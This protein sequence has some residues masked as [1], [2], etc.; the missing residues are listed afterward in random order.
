MEN[1]YLHIK[2]G[3]I[4]FYDY[5]FFGS[6]NRQGRAFRR[7]FREYC[8]EKAEEWRCSKLG[9]YTQFSKG[10]REQI[11]RRWM[12]VAELPDGEYEYYFNLEDKHEIFEQQVKEFAKQL[13]VKYELRILN[14]GNNL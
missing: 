14:S 4:D 13:G 7:A 8:R 3:K 9:N 1:R 10:K 11:A 5:A 2:D 12:A 6:A